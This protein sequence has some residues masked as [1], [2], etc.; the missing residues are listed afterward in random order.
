MLHRRDVF[1]SYPGRRKDVALGVVER[2][3]SRQLNVWF[4]DTETEVGE[5]F[6]P[7]IE[8]GIRNSP[9]FVALL[10]P[11]YLESAWS[12]KEA[13]T[14]IELKKY[15]IPLWYDLT[16][17]VVAALQER[18][19]ELASRT[20]L[21]LDAGEAI[22]D[23]LALEVKR[24]RVQPLAWLRGFQGIILA[25]GTLVA[26]YLLISSASS[27]AERL[28]GGAQFGCAA[29][30]LWLGRDHGVEHHRFLSLGAPEGLLKTRALL[31]LSA[32]AAMTIF[33]A[34]EV[35]SRSLGGF[36]WGYLAGGSPFFLVHFVSGAFCT[37]GAEILIVSLAPGIIDKNVLI[38]SAV[39]GGLLTNAIFTPAGILGWLIRQRMGSAIL[40]AFVWK[41]LIVVP[42]MAVACA[43]ISGVIF[44]S[45]RGVQY[46]RALLSGIDVM[47]W[48]FSIVGIALSVTA[49]VG[50]LDERE[51]RRA[52]LLL[53]VPVF[54]TIFVAAYRISTL[55]VSCIL[56]RYFLREEQPPRSAPARTDG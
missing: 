9:V 56:G 7:R 46:R 30:L 14:A 42:A 18:L 27:L 43:C 23:Q 6:W 49:L 54:V 41:S 35:V 15:M 45:I 39:A 12:I 10:G 21:I 13:Q 53:L 40:E 31:G 37:A 28:A 3:R 16:P 50:N 20:H 29:L 48:V 51:R 55:G 19:P 17:S 44:L 32:F 34:A 33:A 2:L 22:A 47:I 5:R 24:E 25:L 26:A 38:R 4:D 11:E 1:I 8:D 52:A 36:S